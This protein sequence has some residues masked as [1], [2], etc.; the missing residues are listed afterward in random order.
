MVA[1]H[2]YKTVFGA[3]VGYYADSYGDIMIP[4]PMKYVFTGSRFM[5]RIDSE[6]VSLEEWKH[7]VSF[8]FGS[9]T[10]FDL[11]NGV[12]YAFASVKWAGGI[13][14]RVRVGRW[15]H[16]QLATIL[17]HGDDYD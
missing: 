4:D 10:Q 3:T 8:I 2:D 16:E 6:P 14:P 12:W 7:D 5:T 1:L 13:A 15:H 9:D 17:V 11:F